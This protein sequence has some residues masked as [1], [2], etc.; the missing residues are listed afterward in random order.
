MDSLESLL[1]K[2]TILLG[3]R[4]DPAEDERITGHLVNGLKWMSQ[5]H[6]LVVGK[7]ELKSISSPL[8]V[9]AIAFQ[10]LWDSGREFELDKEVCSRYWNQV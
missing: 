7:E 8:V 6:Y 2:Y 9:F 1:D 3:T 5:G 10:K 4:L